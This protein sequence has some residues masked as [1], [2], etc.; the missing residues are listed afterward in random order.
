[1]EEN[2]VSIK[3]EVYRGRYQHKKAER[4]YRELNNREPIFSGSI[5]AAPL[6]YVGALLKDDYLKKG[7]TH[8]IIS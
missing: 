5:P 4:M 6:R 2:V 1:M 8:I 7:Y 3:T